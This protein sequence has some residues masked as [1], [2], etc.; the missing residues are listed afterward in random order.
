[1]DMKSWLDVC[2]TNAVTLSGACLSLSNGCL[3]M[4][5]VAVQFIDLFYI[6][7]FLL[8]KKCQIF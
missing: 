8:F 5:K 3:L 4:N 1:M 7:G 2:I 6:C